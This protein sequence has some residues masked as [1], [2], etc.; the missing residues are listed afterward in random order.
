[1]TPSQVV[2]AFFAA[3]E[4]C[5]IDA[6]QR[7]YHDELQVWH[8]NSD[9]VQGKAEN[10]AAL[11][12]IKQLGRAKYEIEERLVIGDRIAQRHRLH[13]D[14]PNGER[15]TLPVSAFLTVRFGQITRIDEYFD[16]DQLRRLLPP[17]S[18]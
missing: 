10:I 2:D 12:G 16:S 9:T 6:L 5:D 15:F 3:I 17:G 7:L 18:R 13:I 14:R 1:M 4:R 11:A 8:N